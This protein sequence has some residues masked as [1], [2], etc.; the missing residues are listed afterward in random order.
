MES[1]ACYS[2]S[3]CTLC[4]TPVNP[5]NVKHLP[6]STRL[7]LLRHLSLFQLGGDADQ[8]STAGDRGSSGELD[9]GGSGRPGEVGEDLKSARRDGARHGQTADCDGV[10]TGFAR[11]RPGQAFGRL[12]GIESGSGLLALEVAKRCHES[13]G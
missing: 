11:G 6:S 9:A 7:C 3:V 12:E 2:F 13:K 1:S 4:S 10:T 5:V 8:L